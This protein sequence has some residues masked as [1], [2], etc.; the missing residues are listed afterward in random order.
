MVK[1]DNFYVVHGWM[2]TDLGLSGN[3]LSVYALI[4][5]FSQCEGQKYTGGRA[6]L[7]EWLCCSVRTV[8]T[9][10]NSLVDKGYLKRSERMSGKVLLVDYEAVRSGEGQE[11]PAPEKKVPKTRETVEQ[12]YEKQVGMFTDYI[13]E[14]QLGIS[15]EMYEAAKL[16]LRYKI[17]R[18]QDYEPTGLKVLAG[19]IAKEEAEYG[20]KAVADAMADAIKNRYQGYFPKKVFGGSARGRNVAGNDGYSPVNFREMVGS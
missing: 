3:E 8:Q 16:W 13:V 9:C 15:E 14:K 7:S 4:Y 5:G 20:A 19:K 11:I 1:S 10:L 12:R 17:E 6:Y 18:R 2:L